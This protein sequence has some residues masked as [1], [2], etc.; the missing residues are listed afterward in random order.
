MSKMSAGNIHEKGEFFFE[1]PYVSMIQQNIIRISKVADSLMIFF[2]EVNYLQN[3]NHLRTYFKY[4]LDPFKGLYYN[5]QL[6][7]KAL[8]LTSVTFFY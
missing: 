1:N 8:W 6:T 7:V 4:L 2:S 5:Y 3:K